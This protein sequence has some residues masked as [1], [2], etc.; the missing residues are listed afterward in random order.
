[1]DCCTYIDH[2][3]VCACPEH[4]YSELHPFGAPVRVCCMQRHP[5]PQCRDGMVMC[6]MCF[7]RFPIEALSS[8]E[9][10]CLVDVCLECA[11]A[12]RIQILNRNRERQR[13]AMIEAEWDQAEAE[14]L[15]Q[16]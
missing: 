15:Q 9:E 7:S 8:D 13:I 4:D 2:S 16:R 6:C 14:Y 12:E 1:M 5:G 11:E 10:G 3:S